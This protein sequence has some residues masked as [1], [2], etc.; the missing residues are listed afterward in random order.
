MLHCPNCSNTFSFYIWDDDE[1]TWNEIAGWEYTGH[2]DLSTPVRCVQ[3]DYT[4]YLENFEYV[5]YHHD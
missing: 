5:E 3:C 1:Y 4:A 2:L